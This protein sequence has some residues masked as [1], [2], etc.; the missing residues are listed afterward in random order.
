MSKRVEFREE[1]DMF[2]YLSICHYSCASKNYFTFP[3]VTN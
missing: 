3:N 1:C 2:N